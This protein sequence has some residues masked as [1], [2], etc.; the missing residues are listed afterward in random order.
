MLQGGS[1]LFGI[2]VDTNLM[3]MDF[4]DKILALQSNS[5]VSIWAL[6]SVLFNLY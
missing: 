2:D 5:Y 4:K 3:D 6:E 1:F